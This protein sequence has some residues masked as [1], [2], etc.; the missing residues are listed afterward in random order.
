VP[1][2]RQAEEVSLAK[3]IGGGHGRKQQMVEANLRS[4]SRS[5]KSYLGSRL[6]FWI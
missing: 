4:S 6:T 5:Q 1:L 3:R 2:S